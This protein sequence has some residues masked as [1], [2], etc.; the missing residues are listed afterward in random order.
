MKRREFITLLGGAAATALPPAVALP[1]RALPM[2]RWCAMRQTCRWNLGT[3]HLRQ[4]LFVCEGSPASPRSPI[5]QP[6]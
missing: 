4:A 1:I 6:S 2:E 5:G 3:S